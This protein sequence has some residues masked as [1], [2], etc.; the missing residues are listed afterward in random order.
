M[1]EL[2]RKLAK[3]VPGLAGVAH[4]DEYRAAGAETISVNHRHVAM[5]WWVDLLRR[6]REALGLKFT[7]VAKSSGLKWQAVYYIEGEKRSPRQDS[8]LRIADAIEVRFSAMALTVELWQSGHR[9]PFAR[10]L[11][12]VDALWGKLRRPTPAVRGTGGG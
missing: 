2:L 10:V 9:V 8:M 11:C 3:V 1:R 5:V 7:D 12:A 4:G 6:I